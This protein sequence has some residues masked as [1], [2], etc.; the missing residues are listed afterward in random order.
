MIELA[1]HKVA[2]PYLPPELAGLRVAHLTDLHRGRLTSDALLRE[3][4]SIVCEAKPDLILLTGDFVGGDPDDLAPCLDILAPLTPRHAPRDFAP[5]GVYAVPGNHDVDAGLALVQSALEAAG[6]MF[7][8]NRNVRLANGLWLAGLDEDIY[9]TPDTTRAFAG[10][11]DESPVL[12]LVHN[13][14]EAELVADRRCMVFSGHTHGG[15]IW[16]PFLTPCILRR[17]RA[18]H[19]RAGW[20]SVGKA[21]LYV[22]RGLGNA[23][24]PFRL[25]CP[26]E[27]ALFMLAP[28]TA[29]NERD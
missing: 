6:I 11:P 21:E 18:K 15:Q 8:R 22:N 19:Y 24:V 2:V 26:P 3:A 17:I 28:V 1:E 5:L 20:Y 10:I 25:G 4:V 13:P 7:L 14:A 9:G 12:V 23:D 16:L 27:A 29:A